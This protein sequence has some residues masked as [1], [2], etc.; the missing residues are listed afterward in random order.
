[1]KK[2]LSVFLC[3]AAALFSG[4]CSDF[5]LNEEEK[6][7]LPADFNWR[8]YAEINKDVAVSQII[9]DVRKVNEEFKGTDSTAKAV[10][11]CKGLLG[12][13]DFA[14]KI[15]LDYANCPEQGWVRG[16][17][18][19][20][21]YANNSTYSKPDKDSINWTCEI[22]GC[23]H[24]GWDKISDKYDVCTGDEDIDWGGNGNKWCSGKS[25]TLKDTLN[26]TLTRISV[27]GTTVRNYFEPVR[28]MCQF[29]P[30][31]ENPKDAE[32][33]LKKFYYFDGNGTISYGSKFDWTLV[34]KH[35]FFLG[36][37]DGRPYKYCREGHS[38]EEK[39]QSL[40]NKLG[41]Y[42]DYSKYTFCFDKKNNK[43]YVT[44]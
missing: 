14:K 18:C 9:R 32:D 22:T 1:M 31:A 25:Q 39:S 3:A 19:T 28:M 6:L 23:W 11:N 16:E 4:S 2:E 42:Y 7:D 5:S 21:L 27:S 24:G 10:D 43:I 30:K 35:Y 20:G 13:E 33:Y 17:K 12:N 40:A 34:E 41:N 37:N 26:A 8:T 36:R 38:G 44:E 15:Y 29:M